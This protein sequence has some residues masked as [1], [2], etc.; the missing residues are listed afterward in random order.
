M[1]RIYIEAGI[2]SRNGS[3]RRSIVMTRTVIYPD[4]DDEGGSRFGYN[5]TLMSNKQRDDGMR[6]KRKR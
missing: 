4:G 1:S 5:C 3:D 6:G 2:E